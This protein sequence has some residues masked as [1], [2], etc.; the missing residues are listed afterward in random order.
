MPGVA[1]SFYGHKVMP[2][3]REFATALLG[4]KRNV[5]KNARELSFDTRFLALQVSAKAKESLFSRQFSG[6]NFFPLFI[7]VTRRT[8]KDEGNSKYAPTLI[9]VELWDKA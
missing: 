3:G 6:D 5:A 1:S 4:T 9:R 8:K 7:I 2:G